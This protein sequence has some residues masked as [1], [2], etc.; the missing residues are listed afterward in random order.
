MNQPSPFLSISH[1]GQ[2]LDFRPISSQ[3]AVFAD[4]LI[5]LQTLLTISVLVSARIYP[6][7][8]FGLFDPLIT[9]RAEFKPN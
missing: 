7:V 8:F 2:P 4:F 1:R 9:G 6:L 3:S 5:Y